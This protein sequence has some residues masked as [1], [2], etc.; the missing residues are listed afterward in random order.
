[1]HYVHSVSYVAT[2]VH[3]RRAHS[4]TLTNSHSKLVPGQACNPRW[5]SLF[6]V[7]VPGTKVA[8]FPCLCGERNFWMHSLDYNVCVYCSLIMAVNYVCMCWYDIVTCPLH[9]TFW[10][11]HDGF[12]LQRGSH[13]NFITLPLRAL[14]SALLLLTFVLNTQIKAKIT[15]VAHTERYNCC[16]VRLHR[17]I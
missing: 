10:T 13:L 5:Y 11:L 14:Q 2:C 8:P 12:F 7:R 6:M 3:T 16:K 4:S 17:Y 1:M 15:R 9:Y